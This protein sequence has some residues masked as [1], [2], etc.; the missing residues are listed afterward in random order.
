MASGPKRLL[1]VLGHVEQIK[2]GS[3]PVVVGQPGAYRI[4]NRP[5]GEIQDKSKLVI[6]QGAVDWSGIS[7]R[8]QGH[9]LLS[10]V[11]PGKITDAQRNGLIDM[12]MGKGVGP[13]HLDGRMQIASQRGRDKERTR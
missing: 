6:L 4:D 5:W 2:A 1:Q 10:Q 13:S 9:I 12:A 8:D 11:D 7:N 3:Y